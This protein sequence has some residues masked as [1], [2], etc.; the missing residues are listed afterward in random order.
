MIV[1]VSLNMLVPSMPS[2]VRDLATTPASVQLTMT[3]Y[4]VGI[5]CGQLFY[6]PLSDRYGRRPILLIGLGGFVF[7]TLAAL[8]SMSV[9]VL[10]L[11]R[12]AQAFCGCCGM[13]LTR[14]IVR[15]VYSREETA[16][17][18][19]FITM[20]M[21]IGPALSPLI[22]GVF[23]QYLSWRAIFVL[24]ASF[25]SIVVIAVYFTLNETN[26]QRTTSIRVSAVARDFATLLRSPAYVGY[27][28]SAGFTIWCFYTF[29]GGIPH[30][31]AEIVGAGPVEYGA[32][33]MLLAAGYSSGNFVS[34]KLA[35]RIRL[36][37]LIGVGLFT[38]TFAGGLLVAI[39][40][41]L[42]PSLATLFLPMTILT[43][44][45]GLSQPT[46][47][48]SAI[49]IRP[50]IAGSASGLMGFVQMGIAGLASLAVGLQ[51]GSSQM[52]VLMQV[53]AGI[54]VAVGFFVL[55]VRAEAKT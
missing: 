29:L 44:G 15:D 33:F 19:G 2:I 21:V 36:T 13:V 53:F 52:P 37:W 43:F 16:S 12:F 31:A 45:N 28:M 9:E 38:A 35:N 34:G 40:Y 11:S 30:V 17:A 27:I 7:A 48:A 20:A 22:G 8:L 39:G 24:Q 5:A 41:L 55:A 3:L 47:I 49:S 42:P 46:T 18:L 23:D 14:A 51:L 1:N 4:L 32:Y 50:E 10:V 54:V 25:A 26:Y 6:G